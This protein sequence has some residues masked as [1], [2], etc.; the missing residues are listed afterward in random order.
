MHE[1]RWYMVTIEM[2]MMVSQKFGTAGT[3]SHS[4]GL[5]CTDRSK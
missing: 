4:S 2:M 3:G 1:G 5:V